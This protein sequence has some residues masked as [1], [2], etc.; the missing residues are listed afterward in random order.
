MRI[1]IRWTLA[2]AAGLAA[3]GAANAADMAVKAPVY[4]APPVVESWGGFY[5]GG[6]IGFR[7]S[8][9]NVDPTFARDTTLP[10]VLQNMFVAGGCLSGFPCVT[11]APFN[12][13]AFRASPYLGYN[14]QLG[15]TVVGVEGDVGFA[16]QTTTKAGGPYPGTAFVGGGSPT[17]AFSVKTTWDASI[18][19]RGGYL[20]DPAVLLYGTA[21]ASWIH[22]ET[23][24]NCSTLLAADG[25]CAVGGF[26]GLSPANITDSQ[27]KLGYTVGAGI[28]TMLWPNWI[29]RAEYRFADYGKFSNTDI[30][31][32]ATG[33][34]TVA[35]DTSLRTHTATFGLA[36]KFGNSGA[37]LS[38][39]AAYAAVPAAMSPV[40]SWTGVYVGA[41]AGVR[42]NQTTGTLDKATVFPIGFPA[43]DPLAGCCFLSNGFDTTSA[44]VSPYVGYNWQFH[45]KWVAGIEG[46]FGF[47]SRTS[48]LFGNYLPGAAA[49]GASNGL[50]DSFAVKTSWEASIRG[51]IGFLVN[52]TTLI[53]LT[54]GGSWMKVEQTSR[55]DTVARDFL[56]APGFVG[57]EFG[58]CT[59]GLRSPAVIT[60]STVKPGFTIGAGGEAKLWSNWI[61]RGEYRYADYGRASF[62][63]T[64]SC[65]GSATITSAFGT[66]TINCFETDVAVNSLRLQT[67]NAMFGLA[68]QFN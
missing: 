35:Y 47:A 38:A 30:R 28:E 66:T 36:Y 44:K 4:K 31:N 33:T 48:T 39:M 12:G 8:E 2:V 11:G 49:F 5:V 40:F 61:L 17:N 18:R 34:Q 1:V 42:A 15:R 24:S 67:H 63:T 27:N 14:W 10:L 56:T 22:V 53:Y 29:A 32:A 51:R 62:S 20:I 19:A 60:Q 57:S 54:G 45:P 16:D 21:G 52:P 55:C 6:G 43:F 7:A 3:A 13:T 64:R 25:R 26:P 65:A 37:P 46:D 41:A 68:Y 58:A 59:P 9:T 50:N 23:T